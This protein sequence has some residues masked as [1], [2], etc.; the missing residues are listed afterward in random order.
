MNTTQKSSLQTLNNQYVTE[1]KRK[2]K[3]NNY[4]NK[5]DI[6]AKTRDKTGLDNTTQQFKIFAD[7][8]Q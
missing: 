5:N 1:M 2:P 8:M 4:L 3:G 7:G 6:V